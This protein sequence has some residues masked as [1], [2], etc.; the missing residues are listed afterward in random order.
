MDARCILHVDMDAFYAS[1]EQRDNPELRGKPVVVGGGTRGVVAAASYESRE[2]GIRSAMP[3]VEARRRCPDLIRVP[4]RMSHYQAV[5]KQIFAV[6]REFT[7]IVEGLSLDE[8]FL[9]ITASQKLLGDGKRVA[10]EIKKRIREETRL[11]ASVGVAENK[12]VAKIASDLDKPDGLVVVPADD[13]NRI[14]DPLPVAVI[15]GIGRKTL[16][17][18][19]EIGVR[20]V[21]DLRTAPSGRLEPVFGRYTAR[22][23]QR[24]AGID[25]RP[26]VPERQEKS[27]SAE[28][29]FDHD[30]EDRHDME[31][32]LMQLSERTSTRLRRAG[33]AA[34]TVQVKIRESDFTT[35]TRQ[36]S[37]RPPDNGTEA[38]YA[39]AR[40]LLAKW[41]TDHPEARIRLLGVGG[42]GLS[43]ALQGDLFAETDSPSAVDE[44]V[45]AIRERFGSAAMSRAS[46][47]PRRGDRDDG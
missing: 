35:V 39:A 8:A 44:A 5:S 38:I 7:P 33:L 45:D 18:L 37:L 34:A 36:A 40:A 12:L 24:A 21:G 31:H 13:V 28:E 4:G 47:M 41:L 11:T 15:P 27:I 6:F 25:S 16:P 22:T 9:D 32:K 10:A 43:P 2:F 1:I 23:Q 20:T 3:M 42:S 30:L 19:E 26:V 14:L 29:T 46:G 17:R